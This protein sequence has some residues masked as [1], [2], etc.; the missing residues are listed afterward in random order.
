[1]VAD[2]AAD[3]L[4]AQPS[5]TGTAPPLLDALPDDPVE[6][7]WTWIRDAVEAGVPEPHVATLATVD[8]DGVPDARALILKDLDGSGWAVAGQRSSRKG[9]Q[10]AAQPAAALNFWWQQVARAVRVRGPVREASRACSE[11]DLAA[12]SA[13]ARAGVDP[14][15]WVLW[16]IQAVRIEF[17]QGSPDRRHTR[18]VYTAQGGGWSL[19]RNR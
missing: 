18:I 8:A 12:R 7:F 9:A 6:L 17:W 11:A 2:S 19:A 14:A 16:R 1:M 3:W 13:E 10:L 15:D 4:L 5:L